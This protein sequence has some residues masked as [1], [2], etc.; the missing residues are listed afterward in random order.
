MEIINT[1]FSDKKT[2]IIMAIAYVIVMV[3]ALI[4]IWK[5]DSVLEISKYEPYN[6][7]KVAQDMALN[8]FGIVQD[9]CVQNSEDYLEQILSSSYLEYTGQSVEDVLNKIKSGKRYP[10][11][12]D[13]KVLNVEDN[14]IYTG[15]LKTNSSTIPVCIIERYPY[16]IELSFDNFL[17][18]YTIDRTRTQDGVAITL[19]SVCKNVEYI[20]YDIEVLNENATNVSIDFSVASNVYIT[21]DNS[22][23]LY[24]HNTYDVGEAK[25]LEINNN[26]SRSI[27]F[28]VSA[29][30][31]ERIK[32]I[33]FKNVIIDGKSVNIQIEV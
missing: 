33:T 6:E 14:V 8:Y 15:N 18:Y 21:M 25:N 4:I 2:V 17:D 27:M 5:P 3:V 32:S 20:E 19:K 13:I 10:T 7:E 11:I 29:L 1:L 31:Q 26:I 24:L 9:I 30:D 28:N 12:S 16:D 23:I 22:Q